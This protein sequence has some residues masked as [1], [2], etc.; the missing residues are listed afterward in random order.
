MNRTQSRPLIV[1]DFKDCAHRPQGEV[2][3][4]GWRGALTFVEGILPRGDSMLELRGKYLAKPLAGDSD[5]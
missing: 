3:P 4:F 5:Q 2:S 1:K